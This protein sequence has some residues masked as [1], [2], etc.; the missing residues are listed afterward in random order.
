MDDNIKYLLPGWKIVR[1]IGKG[2]FGIVYEV[3]KD[4]GYG[5]VAHSAI[6]VISIP[7]SAEALEQYRDDGYDDLSLTE[8]FRSQ[9]EDITS[10]FA[11]MSKLKGNSNIVSYEDHAIIQH[12]S[13]PGYDIYIRMELLTSLPKYLERHE[14]I[15]SDE[16]AVIKVG[17]DICNALE[18]CMRHNILHRDIKP[19]NIFV[20]EEGDYKLGD[21]G[22]AKTADHTTKATKTGTYGYMA[23]EVYWGKPYNASVDIYSLGMVMYWMLNERRGPFVPLPPTVPKPSQNSDALDLRMH[24]EPLPAPKNGSDKLKQIIL[25]ACAF[26]STDRYASP[27]EMRHDLECI[28]ANQNKAETPSSLFSS[29]SHTFSYAE[30]KQSDEICFVQENSPKDFDQTICE[31]GV[32]TEKETP[33]SNEPPSGILSRKADPHTKQDIES[34]LYLFSKKEEIKKPEPEED[35]AKAISKSSSNHDEKTEQQALSRNVADANRKKKIFLIALTAI[36]VITIAGIVIGVLGGK[37]KSAN[38]LEVQLTSVPTE[39]LPFISPEVTTVEVAETVEHS[40]EPTPTP[41]STP[42]P[43]PTAVFQNATFE[44]AFRAKYGF[45]GTIYQSDILNIQRLDL[46]KCELTDISDIAQFHNLTTLFLG[47]NQISDI[48]SLSGLKSLEY[49]YLSNNQ[50]N[51]IQALSGLTNLTWLNLDNNQISNI[52]SLSG[53]TNLLGLNLDNNQISNITS[54]SGLTDLTWL[55]LDN[56]Q[57]SNISALRGL[58]NLT[59]LYLNNNQISNITSLSGLTNL[60]SLYLNNNQISNITSLSGLTNLTS[61]SLGNNQISNISALRGLTNLQD[62]VLKYNQISDTTALNGLSKLR[63]SFY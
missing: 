1:M 7:E 53:L 56:N 25:K 39:V 35:K 38:Q 55:Y 20:N 27:S 30:K 11:L 13:D 28:T 9:L 14:E 23:P 4:D 54:L 21:F 3:E 58:T 15:R 29:R 17:L 5:R 42:T 41:K 16:C 52:T 63:S 26:D 31:A 61:L 36:L 45:T 37:N 47:N 40:P 8:L 60:T 44:N 51:D 34:T 18:R 62:L 32:Q 57:I 19:Q 24:G 22:I 10:E 46:S 6:K 12:E 33:V 48:Q 43:R 49:L 2:S 59:S 50:I